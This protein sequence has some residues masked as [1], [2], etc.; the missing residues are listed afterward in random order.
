MLWSCV[1]SLPI[2]SCVLDGADEGAAL[3]PHPSLRWDD[4]ENEES[5]QILWKIADDIQRR[6]CKTG[7][8]SFRIAAFSGTDSHCDD[9]IIWRM[10]VKVSSNPILGFWVHNYTM[11][12][13]LRARCCPGDY[14][15]ISIAEFRHSFC[16]FERRNTWSD[17]CRSHS[18]FRCGKY[19]TRASRRIA[20][21]TYRLWNLSCSTFSRR[22]HLVV[23]DG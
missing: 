4:L 14:H 11:I 5:A 15:E 13:R 19:R 10:E 16:V 7:C 23:V 9:S 1:P 22:M 6:H 12:D 17:L 8:P 3:S 18:A 21:A 20:F 2:D